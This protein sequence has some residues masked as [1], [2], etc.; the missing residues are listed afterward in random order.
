MLKK[1]DT[2]YTYYNGM[3]YNR[4]IFLPCYKYQVSTPINAD[5]DLI[6]TTYLKDSKILP[7]DQFIVGSIIYSFLKKL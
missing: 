7:F 2:Q 5:Y 4:F 3:K 1:E 6:L